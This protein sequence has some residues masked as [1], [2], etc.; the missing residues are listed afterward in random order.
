M[1]RIDDAIGT[2]LP[3]DNRMKFDDGKALTLQDQSSPICQRTQRIIEYLSHAK[4]IPVFGPR[5]F[6]L[7]RLQKRNSKNILNQYLPKIKTV[8]DPSDAPPSAARPTGPATLISGAT[9]L[10]TNSYTHPTGL[11]NGNYR[12][13]VLAKNSFGSS[14][15]SGVHDFTVNAPSI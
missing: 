3:T 4:T 5:I 12:F 11:A 14:L 15:F 1:L 9:G 10:T 6:A 8:A 7:P 2:Y 13:L